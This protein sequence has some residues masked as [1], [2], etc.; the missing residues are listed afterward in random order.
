MKKDY[1]LT[2]IYMLDGN[3]VEVIEKRSTALHDL[4]IHNFEHPKRDFIS[5]TNNIG[6]LSIPIKNINYIESLYQSYDELMH[7][8]GN[9]LE[10]ILGA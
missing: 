8:Y 9:R 4:I 5:I 10:E 6:N 3:Y 2:T 7:Y 1:I